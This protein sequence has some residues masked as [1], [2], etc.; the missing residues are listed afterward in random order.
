MWSYEACHSGPPCAPPAV[1]YP[2]FYP[3]ALDC[4]IY[5]FYP[6]TRRSRC[7]EP[8]HKGPC[9]EE[10]ERSF[11]VEIAAD[12]ATTKREAVVGGDRD[13]HLNLEYTPTG[14]G[15]SVKVSLANADS[16]SEVNIT[17]IADGYHFKG[18]FISA[19]PGAKITLDVVNCTAR[20]RW[21]ETLS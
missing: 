19:S 15:P 11:L 9:S 7:H 18:D 8:S 6:G 17:A 5:P 20:L 12:A 21:F 10:A 1:A 13:V 14:T 16:T 4:T 2:W 3:W